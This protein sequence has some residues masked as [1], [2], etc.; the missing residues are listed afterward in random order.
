MLGA[1]PDA[2]PDSN[3]ECEEDGLVE[4]LG[5]ARAPRRSSGNRQQTA[6]ATIEQACKQQQS[7]WQQRR[8]LKRAVRVTSAW[9]QA[10]SEEQKSVAAQWNRQ[11]LR[12]AQHLHGGDH[13]RRPR[14][15]PNTLSCEGVLHVAFSRLAVSSSKKIRLPDAW[16]LVPW[17][18]MPFCVV[19]SSSGCIC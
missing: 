3:S 4:R 5:V 14:G 17:Q 12:V 9:C 8:K 10:V 13:N 16:T 18:P 6:L 2:G 11:R 19:L 15:H 1:L 7:S